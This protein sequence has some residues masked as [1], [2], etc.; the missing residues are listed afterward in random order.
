ML[1]FFYRGGDPALGLSIR[2]GSYYD[3]IFALVGF[4]I[5]RIMLRS[6]QTVY[7]HQ[8]GNLFRR[9]SSEMAIC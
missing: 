9:W 1:A 7:R 6:A 3:W 2:A 8:S 5:L 4:V